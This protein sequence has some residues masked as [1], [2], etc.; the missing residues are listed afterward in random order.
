MRV[1]SVQPRQPK[2]PRCSGLVVWLEDGSVVVVTT[3]DA[4]TK[5]RFRRTH[6]PDRTDRCIPR[7]R[8]RHRRFPRGE[9]PGTRLHRAQSCRSPA[10]RTLRTGEPIAHPQ[11]PGLSIL[12][13]TQR[14][15]HR[16][17]GTHAHRVATSPLAPADS[18][19]S[20]RCP[21]DAIPWGD[22]ILTVARSIPMEHT[23]QRISA[24][25]PAIRDQPPHRARNART[26]TITIE[27]GAWGPINDRI[28]LRRPLLLHDNEDL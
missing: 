9:T 11:R 6:T 21:S 22:C 13:P 7:R 28:T 14:A 12:Q 20:L 19:P 27:P 25:Q 26:L 2:R 1:A 17:P 3:I 8:A 16:D 10:R 24:E 5:A 15:R 23:R 18:R 4:A